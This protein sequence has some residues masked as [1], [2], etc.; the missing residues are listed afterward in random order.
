M[1]WKAR[2]WLAADLS[3]G[4]HDARRVGRLVDYQVTDVKPRGGARHRGLRSL[5]AGD[6][7]LRLAT[8]LAAISLLVSLV[9]KVPTAAE[10]AL[11]DIERPPFGLLA[12]ACGVAR[13]VIR[14]V[15]A[16]LR[17]RVRRVIYVP[18]D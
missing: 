5:F 8:R 6:A 16:L 9:G 15:A 18:V 1:R 12:E 14:D 17:A 3:H 7:F 10:L 11:V 4:V 2:G 13:L